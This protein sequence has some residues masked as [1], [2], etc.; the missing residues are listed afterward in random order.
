MTGI[1]LSESIHWVEAIT[2]EGDRLSAAGMVV[3]RDAVVGVRIDKP[4]VRSSFM[5]ARVLLLLCGGA[6]VAAFAQTLRFFDPDYTVFA[7]SLLPV[8]L[9]LVALFILRP[10]THLTVLLANGAVLAMPSRDPAFL[11]LCLEAFERLWT[12]DTGG[13]ASLYLHAGHR[14]VD[15]GPPVAAAGVA[16]VPAT[17]VPTTRSTPAN[18]S[19]SEPAPLLP[20]IDLPLFGEED[21]ESARPAVTGRLDDATR[22]SAGVNGM[23]AHPEEI[24]A[25]RE[26]L[27]ALDRAAIEDED[28]EARVDQLAEALRT[29]HDPDEGDSVDALVPEPEPD[30][31]EATGR[32]AGPDAQN[33]DDEG[34]A[35]ADLAEAEAA[36][37]SR[38]P[39]PAAAF[40]T[41]RTNVHTLAR[42]LRQR[43]TSPALADAV[44]ILERHTERGCAD[45]REVRALARS[46]SILRGRMTVYPAAIQVLDAVEIAAGLEAPGDLERTGDAAE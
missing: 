41:V 33:A 31:E 3:R 13:Q 10:R 38:A 46:I 26:T 43:S 34:A 35:D 2:L 4:G 25:T 44:D 17:P 20:M 16:A 42:L 12:S 15:F 5:V 24:E 19:D 29:V 27:R 32:A 11:T 45:E 36:S 8:V 21:R 39:I 18:G 14:S 1:V 40:D 28:I 9:L 7:L 37:E 30:A 23:V 6:S 22:A